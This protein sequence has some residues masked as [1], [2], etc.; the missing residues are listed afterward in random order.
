MTKRLLLLN[1]LAALSLPFFHAVIYGFQ[2]M[3]FWTNEYRP[4][5]TVPNYDQWGSLTYYILL[6][7]RQLAGFSIPYFLF[8]TGFF[9]AFMAGGQGQLPKPLLTSR[10]RKLIPPLLIWTII[11]FILQGR[12][13]RSINE[14]LRTYYYIL[15]VIQ[16][17][18][19]SPWLVTAIRSNWKAVLIAATLLQLGLI[20]LEYTA[21]FGIRSPIFQ[22]AIRLTPIWFFPSR[23]FWFIVGIAISLNLKKF[24]QAI[25][26]YYRHIVAALLLFALLSVVEYDLVDRLTGPEWLGTDFN[27]LGRN[28]FSLM[29]LLYGLAASQIKLPWASQIEAIGNKSLGIYLL[30]SLVLYVVSSLI[31]HL[32]PA[33]LGLQWL[34][35]PLL[36]ITSTIGPLLIMAAVKK[37]PL[38]RYYSYLFG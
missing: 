25:T 14:F 20:F 12:P 17:Y 9:V 4:G 2:A 23:L 34:Y 19:L 37:S 15:L 26:P 36:I 1:G 10:I 30:N 24:S 13:P 16:L 18:W 21:A 28:L 8:I 33:V 5:I 27:G 22:W 11:F 31:Y 38:N 35:Q 7:I 29:A 3:F 32:L 6:T